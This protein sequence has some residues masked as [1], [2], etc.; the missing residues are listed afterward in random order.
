[1]D[2]AEKP[3]EVKKE[4]KEASGSGLKIVDSYTPRLKTSTTTAQQTM[5]D[6]LT[7]RVIP[8]EQANE[9]MR[10]EL[11]DPMWK[12]QNAVRHERDATTNLASGEE[13][14]DTIHR[15]RA[16]KEQE[17]GLKREKK[18]VATASEASEQA[19]DEQLKR[20]RMKAMGIPPPPPP[21]IAPSQPAPTPSPSLPAPRPPMPGMPAP[22]APSMPASQ[23][24]SNMPAP[25]P[26]PG[27]PAPRPPMPGMPAPRPPMPGMPAPRPP[28]PGM[29]APQPMAGMPMMPPMPNM[30]PMSMMP[31]MPMPGMPMPSIG[32][33]SSRNDRGL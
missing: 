16:M 13:M 27:M 12:K 19:I 17:L 9:H 23:P 6:P 25:Q 4:E 28:M 31:P 33:A 10:I 5:V 3:E 14:S 26:M 2:T 20:Q 8:V 11:I 24:T 29:P 32:G 21:T 30:P 22:Q 1:M 15:M 7:N 18:E